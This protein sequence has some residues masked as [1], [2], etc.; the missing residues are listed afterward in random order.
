MQKKRIL[1]INGN[2]R[3]GGVERS[4]TDVLQ[5]L[6]YTKYLVD[7]LLLQGSGEYEKEIPSSVNIYKYDVTFAYGPFFRSVLECIK[8]KKWI[9]LFYRII[10]LSNIPVL[11]RLLFKPC[12]KKYETVIGYRTDLVNLLAMKV[13]PANKRISWWH[14]GEMNISG[15]AKNKLEDEYNYADKIVAVSE[16]CASFLKTDFP[17]ASHKVCVIPNMLC[18][19]EIRSKSTEFKPGMSDYFNII[20][21]GRL[22]PE[23]NMRLCINVANILHKS[24]V[25]F[26]WYIIG[27]GE[28]RN[29]LKEMIDKFHLE[30]L[31]TLTGALSNPYP[32]FY[33]ADLYFHPSL[34]ESQGLTILEAM[35]L[36]VPVIAV[37]SS[38]PLEFMK[39]GE[40][41]ILISNNVIDASLAIQSIMSNR[42]STLGIISKAYNTAEIYAPHNIIPRIDKIL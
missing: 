12:R 33:T 13:V 5:H 17:Q 8:D 25:C 29:T 3:T 9:A 24:N 34:V 11:Y 37:K 30:D 35:A 4:L 14:H 32:Y 28:E 18:I 19:N 42:E 39:N 23:K 20:T 16:H 27:D 22:S 10:A 1:F 38:G 2:L 41:G 6:D 7:L 40:N 31:I 15:S 36:K 26:H 21:V